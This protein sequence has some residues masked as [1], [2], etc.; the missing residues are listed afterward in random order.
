M[1]NPFYTEIRFTHRSLEENR[2]YEDKLD[3]ALQS[4][5]YANRVEFIREKFRE[6]IL[7]G[8]SKNV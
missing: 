3:G 8:G 1:P 4:A 7:K 5:G 6:L 2:A